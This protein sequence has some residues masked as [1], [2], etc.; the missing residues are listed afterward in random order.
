M[1]LGRGVADWTKASAAVGNSASRRYMTEI[2]NLPVPMS[3]YGRFIFMKKNSTKT[4]L[5]ALGSVRTLAVSA[6]LT[7]LCI[8]LASLAKSIFG[9]GPIRFTVENLPIL[10]GSIIYGPIVGVIIA[11]AS[12][13]LSCLLFGMAPLPLITVGAAMIA[14]ISGVVFKLAQKK[15]GSRST[16]FIS[17][18]S[19]HII[20]SMAIKTYQLFIFYGPIVLY[21]IPLYIVISIAEAIILSVILENKGLTNQLKGKN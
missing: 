8:V 6:M 18:I 2:F 9:P 7:A 17:V 13:L 14:L 21:R 11:V 1:P 19:A 16:I 12:D 5:G 15:L 3:V 20:G 4:K 10:L